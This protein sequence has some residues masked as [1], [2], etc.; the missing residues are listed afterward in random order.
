MQER[1]EDRWFSMADLADEL[2]LH[3]A[4]IYRIIERGELPE[5]TKIFGNRKVW[6]E[7]DVRALK[8]ELCSQAA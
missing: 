1:A 5:G 8:R 7:R 6:F 2:T 3:R 4:S